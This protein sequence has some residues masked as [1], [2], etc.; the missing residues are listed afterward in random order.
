MYGQKSS[1]PSKAQVEVLLTKIK[2][3]YNLQKERKSNE[4]VKE[5]ALLVKSIK[6]EGRSK[7]EESIL[8]QKIVNILRYINGKKIFI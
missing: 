7:L 1:L 6:G 2:E 4:V 5:E 8:I 3:Y